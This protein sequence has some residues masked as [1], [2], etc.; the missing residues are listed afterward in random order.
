MLGRVGMGVTLA[1]ATPVATLPCREALLSLYPQI[2]EWKNIKNQGTEELTKLSEAETL[3]VDDS[4]F[5]STMNSYSSF[6]ESEEE[7]IDDI[8]QVKVKILST[9]D[10]TEDRHIVVHVATTVMLVVSAYFCA[11]K[12]PGV[13]VVWS[14][15]GSSLGMII[16][17]IIPC[18]C[19]LKIRSKKSA[20]RFT[21]C[22]AL[23]LLLFSTVIAMICTTQS[24]YDLLAA[25]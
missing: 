5:N 20:M 6:A 19:Y 16:G 4:P 24:N 17:F 23:C 18:S 22:C 25:E 14:I 1:F 2:Q 9:T 12:V 10:D 3:I 8:E 15:L 21:N 13:A 7:N 11:I